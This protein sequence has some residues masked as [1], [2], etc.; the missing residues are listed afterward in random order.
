MADVGD[1]NIA[2]KAN[3]DGPCQDITVT[4]CTFL[5]GHGVS[6]GSETD[7]GVRNILVKNCT[8]QNTGTAIRIKTSRTRGGVVE[9][10]TYRDITMK[11]VDQAI[12]INCFYEDK[13]GAADPRPMPVTGKT[14]FIRNILISNITC[15]N[16]KA[17]GQITGLP[18]SAASGI[19]L[20]NARVTAW[21]GFDIQD[22]QGL[23]FRSVSFTTSPKPPEA[24]AAAG[25]SAFPTP[26]TSFPVPLP[27]ALKAKVL[28]GRVIVAA[29]GTGDFQTVQDAVNAAP[30]EPQTSRPFVIHIRPGIY[31]EVVTVP[32]QKGAVTFEGEDAATTFITAAHTAL[33]LDPAGKPIGT[34]RSAT[35]FIQGDDFT[36]SNITFENTAGNHGQAL[37]I[38][39]GGDR[40]TF[41]KCRFLGWQDTVLVLQRRQYFEDCYVSGVTDFIF[42]AATAFFERCH[43]HCLASG[44]I[45]AASTPRSHPFGFVFDHCTITAEPGVHTWLGRPWRPYSSVTF[46]DTALPSAINPQGWVN[47]NTPSASTTAR[48]AEWKSTGPGASPATRVAWSRQLNDAQAQTLTLA[49]VLGGWNPSS[50]DHYAAQ[51][52]ANY[53]HP[54]PDNIW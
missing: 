1:D 7:G 48:Y 38:S 9:N 46:L 50:T 12:Y 52:Q 28:S 21:A 44:Y 25:E 41:R 20:E 47:W 45:T 15:E 51:V 49:Q 34:F 18:E 22:A 2:F 54:A 33:N 42:G 31:R 26:P 27:P 16:A 10:I 37:A 32:P 13:A 14:P 35:V 29:D 19:T 6:I 17:A 30:D 39:I 24:A 11:D 3:S 23:T 43:I 40:A 4:D 36:A 8:F 5:H 53:R